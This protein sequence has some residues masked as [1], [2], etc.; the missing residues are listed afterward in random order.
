VLAIVLGAQWGDEGKGKIVDLELSRY[1]YQ[2]CVR[3][4]GGNNAGHTVV[5][6]AGEFKLHILPSGILTPGVTNIIGAGAVVDALVLTEELR[7]LKIGGI[8]DPLLYISSKAHLV[9]PWHRALDGIQEEKRD[10]GQAIGTTMRGMGPVRADK[11]ARIGLRVGDLE[12]VK[13]FEDKFED[14]FWHAFNAAKLYGYR[15]AQDFLNVIFKIYGIKTRHQ[16]FN[17]LRNIYIK[18][19]SQLRQRMRNTEEILLSAARRGANILLEGAQGALLDIDHGTYPYV[20][21]SACSA[22]DAFQGSGIPF[23]VAS[24]DEIRVLGVVKAYTT[25]VGEGP[26]P[27]FVGGEFDELVRETGKEK[28]TTTG[29]DRMCAPIDFPLLRYAAD[30]NGFTEIA[31]TK[32]DVLSV[33]KNSITVGLSYKCLYKNR[34]E[35]MHAECGLRG[36]KANLATMPAWAR[37]ITAVRER[38]KLPKEAELYIKFIEIATRTGV[39]YISVGSHREQTIVC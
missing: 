8:D 38:D 36:A 4:G 29:R 24:R 16:N 12:D 3:F 5:N 9:L 2:Y 26:F 19:A 33:L 21:S 13:S 17:A 22:A 30:I 18:V 34:I 28:G 35:C 27:T 25:R 37:D 7:D 6:N 31:I 11:H 1:D 20:T 39:K 10:F 32:L 23:N 15:T 14:S